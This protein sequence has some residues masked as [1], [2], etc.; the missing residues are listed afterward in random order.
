MFEMHKLKCLINY[1]FPTFLGVN[2]FL[3]TCMS[4]IWEHY[5]HIDVKACILFIYQTSAV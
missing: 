2:I 5:R 1:Q 3:T 4:S